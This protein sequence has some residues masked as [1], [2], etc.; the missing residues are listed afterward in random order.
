MSI[1]GPLVPPRHAPHHT[2]IVAAAV[3]NAGHEVVVQDPHRTT[4][5]LP[6]LCAAARGAQPDALLLM[7]SEYNRK[8]EPHT[9]R[10]VAEAL[11]DALPGVPTALYGRLNDASAREALESVPA[12]DVILFG[13][14]EFTATQW[15]EALAAGAGSVEAAKGIAGA[16]WRENGVHLNAAVRPDPD[17]SP[18][19]AWDLVP[20]SA[21]AFA[22]HQQAGD[23]VFPVL[24]SRGCPFPC[25]YC[26]VRARPRYLA[27]SVDSVLDEL[28]AIQA[29]YGARSVFFADPTFCIDRDW[30]LEF[31]RRMQDEQI[32]LRWSCMSRTDRVDAELLNAM[33][34][35]GCWNILFGIESLNEDAL[36]A[37]SK[38]LDP[39]TVG[40][41]LAAAREAGIE[42]IASIMVG[43][44]GD[45]PEGFERTL[46]EL[47]ALNPDFAQFFVLQLDGDEAP[48]GGR[49]LTDWQGAKHDFWG[50]VYAADAFSSEE[51][52]QSLRKHAFRRFYLR[53]RYIGSRLKALA[54]S[55]D[56]LAQ[57]AR[58][59]RGGLLALRMAAGRGGT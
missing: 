59:A 4:N 33:A 14:P 2:A 31:C 22:P 57:V 25:F 38:A 55:E 54:R 43:L 53:P 40:P 19:P 32:D 21:Y 6:P 48:E 18:V 50:R 45:S 41:A 17:A 36:K 1:D 3:R 7:Q 23:L 24:A 10:R 11:R 20:L 52:L 27:R 15:V 51:Q 34:A 47:I 16:G 58:V 13:E 39:S 44:P 37:S 46:D 26:E 28:R 9:Q 12:A 49:F 56:P 29:G 35:A 8:I 5:E 42:S 30:T